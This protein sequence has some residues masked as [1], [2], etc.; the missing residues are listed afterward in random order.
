MSNKFPTRQETAIALMDAFRLSRLPAT[1]VAR[2]TT[3]AGYVIVQG[4]GVDGYTFQRSVPN[5]AVVPIKPGIAVLLGRDHKRRLVI[6]SPDIDQQVAAGIDPAINNPADELFYRPIAQ[7]N[8]ATLACY[9][10]STE[11]D[12]TMEVVILP[13]MWRDVDGTWFELNEQRFDFSDPAGDGSVDSLMP[14]AGLHRLVTLWVTDENT[15]SY[16]ASTPK[17]IID[18]IDITDVQ[19]CE[20]DATA[21][22]TAIKFWRLYGGMTRVISSDGWRDARILINVGRGGTGG[23]GGG[24]TAGYV[25]IQ[26]QKTS[27]TDG[28]GFTSGSW[29]TRDLNT[30]VVDVSNLAEVSANQITLQPGTYAAFISCPAFYVDGHQARLYNVTDSIAYLGQTSRALAS[31]SSENVTFSAV[32]ASFTIETATVF[33]VQH[34]CQTT[35]SSNGLGANNGFGTEVYTVA[36]FI[37]LGSGGGGGGVT[38]AAALTYTPAVSGDWDTPP[39]FAAPALDELAARMTVVEDEAPLT[40]ATLAY[41]PTTGADWDTPPTLTAPALDELA[42]RMTAVED[43]AAPTAAT[44]AYIPA[45]AGDWDTPPSFAAPALDELSARVTVIEDTPPSSTDLIARKRSWFGI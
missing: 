21:N 8:L 29:V 32:V 20:T 11:S 6:I 15:V 44:L 1:I 36:E 22:W 45:D 5:M 27:G 30:E 4:R 23:G 33:E 10:I 16:T 31:G 7:G 19:E 18:E 25:L 40:A 24:G 38:D 2:D 43:E 34:R 37:K 26:D 14:D 39:S 17:S 9:A 28:G 35:K 3:K 13:W 12:P 41:T 42:G